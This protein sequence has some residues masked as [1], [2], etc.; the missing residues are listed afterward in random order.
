MTGKD[1]REAVGGL[2]TVE[3]GDKKIDAVQ[4][5]PKF[6]EILKQLKVL[7]RSSPSDKYLLVT[8]V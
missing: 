5:M 6:K 1:F 7:A 8:G 3:V 4:N 2:I